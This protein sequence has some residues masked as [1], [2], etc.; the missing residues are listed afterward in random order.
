MLIPNDAAFEKL[1]SD[2][3]E[4]MQQD[5]QF[6]LKVLEYHVIEAI[7]CLDGF[8]TGPV[9]SYLGQDITVSVSGKKVMFNTNSS[10]IQADIIAYNGVLQV[11]DTVLIPPI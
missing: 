2:V 4:K 10:L 1:P 11:I 7:T 8:E 3:K 5:H 6:L 9:E